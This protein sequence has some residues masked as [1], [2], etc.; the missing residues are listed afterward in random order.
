MTQRTRK[1]ETH[2]CGSQLLLLF[3]SI[4][5]S[6][7]C[8]I[9]TW[10]TS[11]QKGFPPQLPTWA[12]NTSVTPTQVP[13]TSSLVPSAV[14]I[15]CRISYSVF[16]SSLSMTRFQEGKTRDLLLEGSVVLAGICVHSPWAKGFNQCILTLAS[17]PSWLSCECWV[18]LT[19]SRQHC[20]RQTESILENSHFRS[21]YSCTLILNEITTPNT[22]KKNIL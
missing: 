22:W 1:E 11:G 13:I 20:R 18:W 4:L 15:C 3:C 17:T 16:Q 8:K 2:V 9:H 10:S 19:Q 21:Q 14:H 7:R 6:C 12:Y 5:Y